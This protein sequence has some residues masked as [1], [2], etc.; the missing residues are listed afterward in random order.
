VC[1]AP[2]GA[3]ESRL[4][5]HGHALPLQPWSTSAPLDPG[6]GAVI[7]QRRVLDWTMAGLALAVVPVL[8]V[9]NRATVP[10]LQFGARVVN[11]IIWL[12]F[13]AEFF[14]GLVHA[15]RRARFLR[16]NWFDLAII[17]VSPPFG[18]PEVLQGTR[19][20]RA[21]RVLRLLRLLRVAAVM[22]MGLKFA[23]R[24]LARRKFHY[25]VLVSLAVVGLGAV[26]IYMTEAGA[27]SAIQSFGDAV[28]WALVTV[29]TVGY[30]DVSPI[31]TEGRVIAVVLMFTGIGVIGIFTATVAS[32]FFEH[33]QDAEMARVEQRLE[34]LEA[35]IDR[36]LRERAQADGVEHT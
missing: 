17:V 35:K 21:F 10:A 29:T 18:V 30:G 27:N 5:P 11:W 15:N 24:G 2:F 20:L 28:W 7:S 3:L 19:S 12:A 36:L 32:L 1:R 4:L 33:D 13:C 9:E 8:L 34:G 25:V 16:A 6:G 31:T 14:G 22:T 23:S 26:G